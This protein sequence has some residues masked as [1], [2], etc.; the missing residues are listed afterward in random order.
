MVETAI[1]LSLSV[2]LVFGMIDLG[3][4]VFRTQL[5]SQAARQIARQAIVHGSLADRLGSWGPDTISETMAPGAG[6]DQPSAGDAIRETVGPTLIGLDPNEVRYTLEWI[7]GGN[8]PQAGHRVRVTVRTPFRPIMTFI[9]GN[10][11]FDLAASSTMLI[12][13]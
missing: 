9:F 1:T 13:H 8:D 11:S 10:P 12:A 4:W 7:D 5:L 6:G 3:F 2:L